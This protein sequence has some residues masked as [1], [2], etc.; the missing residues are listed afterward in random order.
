MDK[1]ISD[2]NQKTRGVVVIA[3]VANV[4]IAISKVIAA[5]LTGSSAM[6]AEAAHTVV[7]TGNELS[8][9]LGLRLA[10]RPADP[11]H[12][13]GYGKERYFWPLMASI[14]MFVIGGTFS[15]LRA[16]QTIIS[17]NE[18]E[19]LNVNYWVLGASA[20]FDGTSFVLAF[21]GLRAQLG[22]LG[23]WK[24]IRL[25][26]DPTL[27]NVLFEDGAALIGL[28]L[29]F[30]GLCLY[31]LTGLVIFDSLAS[32]LI[33]LLLGGVAIILAY[34]SR[35]LLLGEAASPETQQKIIDAVNQ[36]P[37]VVQVVDLLTMHMGPDDILVNMD[38]NLRDGLTTDHVEAA[39]DRVEDQIKRTIP[40]AR[41]IFVEC[42][43]LKSR[44]RTLAAAPGHLSKGKQST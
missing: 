16:I 9:L 18:I 43:T 27:F 4:A 33:G 29:A 20:V 31:Q 15:V 1:T 12:P 23:L 39:I 30:L 40:Q 19:Y 38:L 42:E 10:S 13:F 41:R 14:S 8:L 44:R 25:T 2:Q 32:L 21:K 35:S 5:F 34:E 37:E 3:L 28:C 7:D 22:K 17:P 6:L 24:A 36:V 11:H 26:K